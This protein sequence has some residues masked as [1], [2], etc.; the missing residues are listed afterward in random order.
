MHLWDQSIG[1][2]RRSSSRSAMTG[3][4]RDGV[5]MLHIL[6][7]RSVGLDPTAEPELYAWAREMGTDLRRAWASCNDGSAMFCIAA[8]LAAR[9]VKRDPASARRW[10]HAVFFAGA[11]YIPDAGLMAVPPDAGHVVVAANLRAAIDI[12]ELLEAAEVS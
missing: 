11:G 2:G 9:A 8:F 6:G 5:S 1:L 7:L 12:D 4:V 3:P 10:T